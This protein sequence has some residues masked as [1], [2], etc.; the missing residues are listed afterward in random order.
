M[1]DKSNF[2]KEKEQFR[3]PKKFTPPRHRSQQCLNRQKGTQTKV[4]LPPAQSGICKSFTPNCPWL[5]KI[6]PCNLLSGYKLIGC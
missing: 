3:E 6:R 4:G 5:G 1:K 2:K